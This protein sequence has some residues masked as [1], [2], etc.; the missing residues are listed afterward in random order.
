MRA[1]NEHKLSHHLRVESVEA[2]KAGITLFAAD[3]WSTAAHH[4]AWPTASSGWWPP[5]LLPLPLAILSLLLQPLL[6]L[7][8]RD[9][10]SPASSRQAGQPRCG[11]RHGHPC[12]CLSSPLRRS[13]R[14]GSQRCWLLGRIISEGVRE[15]FREKSWKGCLRASMFVSIILR[16]LLRIWGLRSEICR[17]VPLHL[18]HYLTA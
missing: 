1:S 9:H 18:V 13:E 5:P 2:H 10:P 11:R 3:C 15:G 6:R 16:G 17:L 12:G 4:C 14:G 7:L 8:R